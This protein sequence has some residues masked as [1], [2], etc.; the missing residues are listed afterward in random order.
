LI[1]DGELYVFW[2]NKFL[3]GTPIMSSNKNTIQTEILSI[4]KLLFSMDLS[5][6]EYQSIS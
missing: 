4:D 6:P 3:K 5:I 2:N 1:E